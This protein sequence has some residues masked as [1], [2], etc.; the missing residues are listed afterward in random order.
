VRVTA[1]RTVL[2]LTVVSVRTTAS[3]ALRPVLTAVSA[4]T[5]S[6]TTV[7][8][9]A[10]DGTI[11]LS[12]DRGSAD[13]IVDV[14]GW[15]P[16][17]VPPGPDPA[18][19]VTTGRTHLTR[20][21]LVYDGTD[22]PLRAGESRTV[23]LGGVGPVPS[24]GLTGLDLTLTTDRAAGSSYVGVQGPSGGG[25][26]GSLRSSTTATRAAQVVAPTTDGTLVLR[27]TGAYPAVVHLWA[28]AWFSADATEGGATM[29]LLPAPVKVVDSA[30]RRGLSG[31]VTS[32]AARAMTLP[33]TAVPSGA[34]G[35]LLAVS[36]AGGTTDGTLVVGSSGSVAAVSF[37]HGQ[38]AHEVV[39]MPLVAS[40]AVA[41]RTASI[42][43]Q[44]RAWVLG[45]V[46]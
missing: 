46:T 30:A 15:A 6:S 12:V 16:I 3:A 35:V 45:Y 20:P 38:S 9:V 8:P 44:V 33:V 40:G 22:A 24:A 36:A 26:V 32:T 19:A 1:Y 21:V 17:A 27:N 2:P 7:V 41:F 25:Y 4:A 28:N 39:L 18:V 14:V 42:G 34:R 5:Y 10:S 23:H 13:L 37:A 43:T 29:T 11:R 31:P